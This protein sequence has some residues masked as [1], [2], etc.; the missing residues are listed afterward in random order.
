LLLQVQ[1]MGDMPQSLFDDKTE[2][3]QGDYLSGR[4]SSVIE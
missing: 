3:V 4:I 2:M 1:P